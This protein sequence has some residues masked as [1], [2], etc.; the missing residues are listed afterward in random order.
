LARELDLPVIF[1]CRD[2]FEPLFAV[3]EH[4]APVRGVMH[5][6][7]GTVAEARRALD[8]GLYLSYAGPL[9]YKKNDALR[10]ACAFTPADRVLVETDAPFLP[11][12]SRR[13]KRNEP[14]LIVET[15][16]RL[17]EVRDLS[18]ADAAALTFDNATRLFG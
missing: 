8:L 3:L 2:A 15:L 13:G 18:L 4:E 1:H 16:T 6:F 12:Q 17:A 9:T 7:S 5:C 14:A 10:E 11:P